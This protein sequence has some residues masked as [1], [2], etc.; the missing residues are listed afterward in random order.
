MTKKQKTNSYNN[1]KKALLKQSLGSAYVT[2]P[3]ALTIL[4]SVAGSLFGFSTAVISIVAGT[5]IIAVGGFTTEY[6]IRRESNMKRISSELTQQME[7]RRETLV[8]EIEQDLNQIELVRAQDQLASFRLKFTTFVDVLEDRFSPNELTFIRYL[9]VAE[10]V[11]LS[12]IDNLRDAIISHK[13]LSSSNINKLRNRV[14]KLADN[15]KEKILI[16]K[17]IQNFEQT[18]IHIDQLFLVN[19]EALCQLDDVTYK[20]AQ[21]KVEKGMADSD[22]QSAMTEL[23]RLGSMLSQ[24][25]K[26]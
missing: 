25:A 15:Q 20:I 10:Q 17:R 3:T 13:A 26:R 14:N 7:D 16:Q 1:L 6:A 12:G 4:G 18:Q 8:N 24:Y 19:E 23:E 5:A 11:Y 21:T 9:N 2:Y 22:T